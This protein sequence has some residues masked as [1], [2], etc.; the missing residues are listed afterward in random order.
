VTHQ[1]Y[2]D[3]DRFRKTFKEIP[4]KT[5][6]NTNKEIALSKLLTGNKTTELG[7]LDTLAS[8]I[9]HYRTLTFRR[10]TSTIVDVPH[11]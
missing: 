3:A 11:R 5:W 4:R 10:L 1:L 8:E 2:K 7:R 6:P 9:K